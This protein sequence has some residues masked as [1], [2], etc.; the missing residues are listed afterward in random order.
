MRTAVRNPVDERRPVFVTLHGVPRGWSAQIP[1]AWVWLDGLGEREI[2]IAIWPEADSEDYAFGRRKDDRERLPGTAPLRA[3]GHVPRTYAEL[4]PPFD[5]APGARFAAIGGTFYRVHVRRRA[6]IEIGVERI[7]ELAVLVFGKVD[8]PV[9]NQR[10]VVTVMGPT[11]KPAQADQTFTTAS[12]E[13][14]HRMDLRPA[15]AEHGTGTYTVRATVL[16]ADELE[17]A[18]SN[19]VQIVV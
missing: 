17:D 15:V 9:P 13:L 3:S 7:A 16:D 11:G 5:E 4:Q 14:Q 12:G 2:D 10:V 18:E 19:A 8:P 1:H 6:R